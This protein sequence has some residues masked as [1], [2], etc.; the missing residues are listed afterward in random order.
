[1]AKKFT[2]KDGNTFVEVKPWY[3]KWWIWVI[4]V[5]V[6]IFAIGAF[7]SGSNDSS[8]TS[9][10]THKATTSKTKNTNDSNTVS[11]G[12]KLSLSEDSFTIN[13]EVDYNPNYS[14]NS[15]A[16]TKVNINKVRVIKIKTKNYYDGDKTYP[17]QGIIMVHFKVTPTRDIDFYPTQ[18]TLVTNGQQVDADSGNSDD[19]DGEISKGATQTGNVVFILKKMTDV[20][21][22]KS[23]RLKWDADYDT[24]NYDDDNSSKTYDITINLNN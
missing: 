7:S 21:T 18:G 22:I 19:F 9:P 15:W 17:V 6:V 3:K 8:S 2:D 16:Q 5:I 4:A 24:D 11:T 13:K 12:K 23:I 20:N 1:M 14:D 10:K